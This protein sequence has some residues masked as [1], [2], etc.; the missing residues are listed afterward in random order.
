MPRGR[1]QFKHIPLSVDVTPPPPPPPNPPPPPPSLPTPTA[2]YGSRHTCAVVCA[3]AT[4]TQRAGCLFSQ[5]PR[6][7]G[8][9]SGSQQ[10][11]RAHVHAPQGFSGVVSSCPQC[12]CVFYTR[13][14]RRRVVALTGV[15]GPQKRGGV[16]CVCVCGGGG[17]QVF[18]SGTIISVKKKKPQRKKKKKSQLA[19]GHM[20]PPPALLTRPP[21]P[22]T[23]ASEDPCASPVIE[24]QFTETVRSVSLPSL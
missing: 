18:D 21:P 4:H 3:H 14:P 17:P 19:A 22:H 1:C 24:P 13:C 12:F 6:R 15:V 9:R 11:A 20:Y 8:S 5:F 7:S 2:R 10:G 23:G 16:G